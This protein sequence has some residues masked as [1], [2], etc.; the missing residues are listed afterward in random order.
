MQSSCQTECHGKDDGK[1]KV[2]VGKKK[3]KKKV[4]KSKDFVVF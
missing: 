3:I 2:M 1:K 4:W